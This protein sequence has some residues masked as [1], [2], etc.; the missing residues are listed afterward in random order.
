M[1]NCEKEIKEKILN[2]KPNMDKVINPNVA[3]GL[4]GKLIYY[5]QYELEKETTTKS[6]KKRTLKDE[7]NVFWKYCPYCGSKLEG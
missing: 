7:A 2:L 1:C 4:D 3:L 5:T 6:G